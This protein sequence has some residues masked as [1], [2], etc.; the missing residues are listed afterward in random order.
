MKTQYRAYFTALHLADL[1]SDAVSSLA[2]LACNARVEMKALARVDLASR[3]FTYEVPSSD[4]L[5]NEVARV[6][7][8]FESGAACGIDDGLFGPQSPPLT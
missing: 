2:S 6:Q 5:G 1:A 8:F 7:I 4:H 3:A